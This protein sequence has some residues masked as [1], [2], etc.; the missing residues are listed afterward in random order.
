M[1][2]ERGMRKTKRF[3][4]LILSAVMCMHLLPAG[5]VMASGAKDDTVIVQEVEEVVEPENE[6]EVQPETPQTDTVVGET[7]DDEADSSIIIDDGLS[8]DN[9]GDASDA[10]EI[11]ELGKEYVATF[12]SNEDEKWFKFVPEV[13]GKYSLYSLNAVELSGK[14]HC[15]LY[16]ADMNLIKE[17]GYPKNA[18][19]DD[20]YITESLSS[21]ITY[22]LSVDFTPDY[23]NETDSHEVIIV[24]TGSK[25]FEAYANRSY[26]SVEPNGSATLSTI[27]TGD[28]LE[29]ITFEWFKDSSDGQSIEGATGS[30]YTI[31]EVTE[32]GKYYCKVSNT[33][34]RSNWVEFNVSVNNGFS[35]WPSD[36]DN[37]Y[38][39]TITYR[40][41]KNESKTLSVSVDALDKNGI[42]Y[43]WFDGYDNPIPE[44]TENNY[45]VN[46]IVNNCD[47]ICEVTDRYG[48]TA[49]LYFYIYINNFRA[50]VINEEGEETTYIRYTVE[51]DETKVLSVNVEADEMDGIKYAWYENDSSTIIQGATGDSYTVANIKKSK[52]FFCK[53]TDKYGNYVWIHFYLCIDNRLK[54]YP[55]ES[56]DTD[57]DSISFTVKPNESK[58]LSVSVEAADM[59]GITYQ[60]TSGYSEE[61]SGATDDSYTVNSPKANKTYYCHIT[62][63][64]GNSATVYFDIIVDN[65]LKAYPADSSDHS[66]T[67]YSYSIIPGE[68]KTLTVGV[69]ANDTDGITYYWTDS[70]DY[71]IYG[72][73]GNSYTLE[74]IV[75]SS[76]YTCYVTDKFGNSRKV[77]FDLKINNNLNAFIADGSIGGNAITYKVEYNGSKTLAVGVEA[78]DMEDITYRWYGNDGT[79]IPRATDS[80]YTVDNIIQYKNYRCVVTDKYGNSYDLFFYLTVDN[81]LKVYTSD[82]DHHG[83]STVTY[84]VQPNESKTLSVTVEAFDMDGIR[85][86]WGDDEH[87]TLEATSNTFTVENINKSKSYYCEVTDK[88]GNSESVY[89]YIYIDN[90]FKAYPSESENSNLDNITFYVKPNESKNLSVNVDAYDK[91]GITYSW[92]K[93]GN[94]ML[95][96]NGDSYTVEKNEYVTEYYCTV[97]DRYGN[98]Q[99]IYFYL[100]VDNGFKAYPSD[101]GNKEAEEITYNVTPGDDIVLSVTVEADSKEGLVYSWEDDNYDDIPGAS[102]STFTVEKIQKTGTYHCHVKDRYGNSKFIRFNLNIDNGFN[103]YPSDSE[104]HETDYYSYTIKPNE[105]KTLSVSVDAYDKTGIT[106]CWRDNNWLIIQDAV[107]NSFTIDKADRSGTYYC[108]VSDRY[109]NSEI[110]Y[111]NISIDNEFKAYPSDAQNSDYNSMSYTLEPNTEKTL[112]VSVDAVDKEGITYTW[113]DDHENNIFGEISS[114]Y[115]IKKA[116]ATEEY[117][118]VVTDRYGNTASVYFYI[119]IDNGFKAYVAGDEQYENSSTSYYIKPNESKNLSVAVEAYDKEGITYRWYEEDY[120]DDDNDLIEGASGSSYTIEKCISNSCYYCIVADRYG[121]Y[122]YVWFYLNIDNEL[123]AY[124]SDAENHDDTSISYTIKPNEEKTLSVSVDAYDMDGI[125]YQWYDDNYDVIE[126]ATESGYTIKNIQKNFSFQ[127]RVEDKYGNSRYVYFN[128]IVDN[129]LKISVDGSDSDNMTYNLNPKEQKTLFA[130]VSATNMKGISYKWYAS[131]ENG[132]LSIIEGAT[133]N[134]Y[135]INPTRY[136][137]KYR[138]EATDCYGNSKSVDFYI[139][140]NNDFKLYAKNTRDTDVRI[141]ANS[142]DVKTLSVVAEGEYLEGMTYQWYGYND[143]HTSIDAIPGATG[144]RYVTKGISFGTNN[145]YYYCLA[146]DPYGNSRT[147]YFYIY[148]STFNA[149]A[150]GTRTTYVIYT[151][152]PNEKKELSVDV[153]ADDT[154]DISYSW[155]KYNNDTYTYDVIDGEESDTLKLNPIN[156]AQTYKCNVSGNGVTKSV[157]F[158]LS[159]NHFDAFAAGTTNTYQYI[160]VAHGTDITLSVDVFG[161]DLSGVTYI[162]ENDTKVIENATGKDLKL[163]NIEKQ[164]YYT[165]RVKDGYGNTKSI[166]FRININNLKVCISG[167]NIT[168]LSYYMDTNESKT[169]SIDVTADDMKGVTYSWECQYPGDGEYKTVDNTTNTLKANIGSYKWIYYR[170]YVKDSYGNNEY[171]Y[172]YLHQGKKFSAYI[173]NTKLTSDEINAKKDEKLRLELD[174]ETDDISKVKYRWNKDGSYVKETTEPYIITEPITK[175]TSYSCDLIDQYGNHAYVRFSI[176]LNNLKAYVKGTTETEKAFSAAYGSKVNLAVDLIADDKSRIIYN[177]Y[178]SDDKTTNGYLI[179]DAVGKDNITTGPV[180]HET[181]YICKISNQFEN[182]VYVYFRVDVEN[183]LKAYISGTTEVTKVFLVP[184]GDSLTLKADVTASDMNEL[185]YDWSYYIIGEGYYWRSI[186]QHSESISLDSVTENKTYRCY[187]TDRYGNHRS[188]IYKVYV[189]QFDDVPETAGYAS[190]VYWALDNEITSGKTANLFDPKGGCTRA[191]FVTFLWRLAGCPEPNSNLSFTDVPSSR[192]YCKAVT[193]AAENGITVGYTG[194]RAGQFGPNDVCT[195]E[196][197]VTFMYRYHGSPKVSA[198][199]HE[200]YKFSDVPSSAY[201]Y[202]AV[203]W[204]AKNGVTYGISD[205]VFGRGRSCTRSQM[206]SFLNRFYYYKYPYT[207]PESGIN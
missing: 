23:M 109:G 61:I 198:E 202:D 77:T 146:T 44:A 51:P 8:D 153:V 45:T 150:H 50:Y 67:Y 11:T 128:I 31:N 154:S 175:N 40:I 29:G 177:W 158:Y 25:D 120:N 196:Q 170:C 206:V 1:R 192:F 55:S 122:E 5:T 49:Y 103:A 133:G 142:G 163:S 86:Y 145:I 66:R 42:T 107:E 48:N 95:L 26:I 118:C 85:Y 46:N 127:C 88:F 30:T 9:M 57:I 33:A 195:R 18:D 98:S 205:T 53:V 125:T 113:L 13:A 12:T 121:N 179:E 20:F 24:V 69:E 155:Y 79:I 47:Y 115:T 169:L 136:Y 94:D 21:G 129:Q 102:D 96:G 99:I 4:A 91:E 123:K 6:P 105:K 39:N 141:L 93:Y 151:V 7:E 200:K 182:V 72:I 106:Y 152:K 74:N 159:V 132:W 201:Y 38:S 180:N 14:T 174:V 71:R 56:I 76:K 149:Y 54:A 161:D 108:T 186:D 28:D 134:S 89:F 197:C 75:R 84:Y 82:A 165:C 190:S 36:N 110:V 100:Y 60:W 124:P 111:F 116:D 97:T 15:K 193:W 191:Q 187:I 16:D 143:D 138:F 185:T 168:S 80:S 37:N 87:N 2:K 199:D 178:K 166:S 135:T 104:D 162:W 117:T 172:F 147:V 144:T 137:T 119:T 3:T 78:N 10:V 34:H 131:D 19:Y 27:V 189:R 181:W 59:D 194:S 90:G 64:Y 32:T 62:D 204:A 139:Y 130:Q 156:S 41:S 207:N 173:K 112:S 183:E 184:R 22:Y 52:I 176:K 92:R 73:T 101:A 171:V 160:N 81:G 83:D 157:T 164:A 68:S 58:A 203:T 167:T 140:V 188:L 43:Q 35:A 126:G 63:K 70:D 148:P 114:S 17:N 65:E